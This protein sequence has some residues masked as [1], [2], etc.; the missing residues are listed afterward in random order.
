[1]RTRTRR[2]LWRSG[3]TAALALALA[4]PLTGGAAAAPTVPDPRVADGDL[5]VANHSFEDGLEGWTTSNGEGDTGPKHCAAVP[6]TTTSW[7]A[8]GDSALSLPGTP[9]CVVLGAVSSP[10]AAVAGES[11]T[12]FAHT[13]GSGQ[14]SI[15]LRFLDAGGNV[16][17]QSYGERTGA[18]DVVEHTA[19][20]PAGATQVAVELGGQKQVSFD[21]V[22][23]TGEYTKLAPQVTKRGSFLAMAAGKDQNGRAV[24]FAVATGSTFNP[25]VLVVTDILTAEVTDTVELPG[26]TG[27]WTIEQDPESLDVYVGTYQGP[28]LYRSSTSG[29]CTG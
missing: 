9:P 22:L 5:L 18:G 15:G 7:S 20:A 12:A 4:V 29:S 6:R 16:V 2:L 27:S 3:V 19:E 17:A 23:I 8:D 13:D 26:A 21:K 14:A 11:Y 24:T 25:A 1:M 28:A 10:V